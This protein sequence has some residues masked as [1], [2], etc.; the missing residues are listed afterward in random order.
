MKG[1]FKPEF[2]NR[3]DD[4]VIFNPLKIEEIRKIVE[5]IFKEIE[6]KASQKSIS[7]SLSPEAKDLI[8]EIGFDPVY[9]ARPLR[10]AMYEQIE[11]RLADLILEGRL[12]D[13]AY[14]E[15][16]KEGDEIVAKIN[17]EKK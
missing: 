5:I 3:L 14:I 13:G 7:I 12:E 2:L 6:L 4:I 16:V 15:F 11:D 10:R 9:G 8:A 1:F 17:P